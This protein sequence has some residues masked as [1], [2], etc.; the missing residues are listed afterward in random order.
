MPQRPRI[1]AAFVAL[2]STA[3][4]RRRGVSGLPP[5]LGLTVAAL[6]VACG[7]DDAG[8]R[9]EAAGADAI[10]QG[11]TQAQAQAEA[12][13]VES[14]G[15]AFVDVTEEAGLSYIQ[16]QLRATPDCLFTG[17]QSGAVGCMMERATGGAATADYDGDGWP[18][19]YVTRL[20]GPDILFRNQGDGTFTDATE[21][22]GLAAFNLRTNGVW[23]GDID[24]DGDADLF[25]TT[26]AESRFLLFINDGSGHFSEEAA[27]RGA[28][29][30]DDAP[31]G[32]QSVAMGDFD[33]DGWLDIHTTE[34][35]I[36]HYAQEGDAVHA[37]LLRN[38]GPDAPGYFEDVTDAAGVSLANVESLTQSGV[39][40]TFSFGTAFVDLDGDGWQDLAVAGDFGRSR[41]FWNNR[42]G[43]FTDGTVEAGVGTDD[44][45][46]GSTFG[47]FDADGDLDW[48][49]TSIHDPVPG[50]LGGVSPMTD[51]CTWHPTGN[52]LYRYD[53]D[54]RFSDATDAAGVR[55]GFWGWGAAF[56]DA[57]N[58]GDLDLIMTNGFVLTE[59]EE[60]FEDD[61]MRL[62]E[63]DGEGVLAERS[64]EAGISSTE[65]GKGLL[66]F[67]YD[68][69]GDLDVFVVNN[70]SGPHLYRN[71]RGND[72]GWL[73]IHLIGTTS[74]RDALGARV[75]VETGARIAPQVREVGVSTHFLGQS[76]TTLH[77]GLGGGTDAVQRVTVTWP[78]SGLETVLEHVPANRSII[79]R[80]GEDGFTVEEGLARSG[81]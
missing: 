76:E 3:V 67:D 31:R 37:R 22:A 65:A 41:L 30:T 72:L 28:A 54:R 26:V 2:V 80:E 1:C 73:R 14:P 34:W 42:D 62:W 58:D 44:N 51:Q 10:T 69:D 70:A 66:T 6:I 12:L 11:D 40:G 78:A 50:C 64:A 27:L 38:R 81:G 18:D 60:V 49:V 15:F 25:V 35:R 5:L 33:R 46:M 20:D 48:F 56:F 77:F 4:C 75:V 74:N 39:D 7:G 68:R 55:E 21:A 53:G 36:G 16:H 45:G 71:E 43:T 79:V 9:S 29:V 32:G 13:P 59:Q 63:N 24:N 23:W 57:D 17:S 19:L 47:D 61:P 52:R 8:A